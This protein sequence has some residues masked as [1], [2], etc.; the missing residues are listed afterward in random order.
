MLT[1]RL[2]CVTQDCF[3]LSWQVCLVVFAAGSGSS[4]S[5]ILITTMMI[6]MIMMMMIIIIITPSSPTVLLAILI[7]RV[8]AVSQQ[9][10]M[11]S[12]RIWLSNARQVETSKCYC[13]AKAFPGFCCRTWVSPLTPWTTSSTR[14]PPRL[15][16]RPLTCPGCKCRPLLQLLRI[17]T[18]AATL[19]RRRRKRMTTIQRQQLL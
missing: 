3:N 11:L 13:P 12:H 8:F 17:R 16:S 1:Y 19:R 14:V 9:P 18:A 5:S 7:S 2:D 15:R 6:R 4:S 10:R